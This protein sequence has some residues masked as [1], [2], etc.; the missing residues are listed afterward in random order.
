MA[1]VFLR[2]IV[3]GRPGWVV[4]FWIAVG[5]AMCCCDPN[6]TRLAAE[7]TRSARQPILVGRWGEPCTDAASQG[8]SAVG[9]THV[10]CT[11]V[12]ARDQILARVASTVP[13]AAMTA[14]AE[15]PERSEHL[16]RA[17]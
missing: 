8:L 3:T 4:V 9:A 7:R 15:H 13:V 10:A 1:A 17:G 16:P 5:G 14:D 2:S 12:D 11:L 6:L